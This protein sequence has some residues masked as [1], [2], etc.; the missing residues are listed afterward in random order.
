MWTCIHTW[1]KSSI[2]TLWCL[3]GCSIGDLGTIY[4]FQNSQYEISTMEVMLLAMLNGL[5]T[6]FTIEVI[7]LLKSMSVKNAVKTAFGMSIV[8]MISMEFAMNYTDF[9]L[10]GAAIINLKSLPLVLLA[11]FIVPLPY[12][13]WK[14]K[15]TGISC[16]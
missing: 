11:G 4:F 12:N 10:N 16:H 1:K 2:N 14:L 13:Y 7:V 6:S 3:F 5:I 9:I 15:T 8:S